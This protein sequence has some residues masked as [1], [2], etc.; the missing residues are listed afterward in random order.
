MTFPDMAHL[1]VIIW[2]GW[3]IS[4]TVSA[5]WTGRN[6]R[7]LRSCDALGARLLI[8]FGALMLTNWAARIAGAE[9]LWQT[10]RPTALLLAVLT[11]T[12]ILFAWWARIHLGLM[13]SG[14]IALKQ[15]HR[16]VESGPYALVRH[17]I[18]VGLL[19]A[20]FATAIAQGTPTAFAGWVLLA[21]GASIKARIEERFLAAELASDAYASYRSR[22]PMMLPFA[23]FDT[24]YRARRLLRSA[25][26]R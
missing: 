18:Y 4:W 25:V 20:T 21:C 24:V 8:V 17:P 1:F 10:D 9:R 23:S 7:R 15:G 3:A 13:W 26:C 14:G 2:L 5:V 22:V 12:G 11:L 6:Y 19:A 16:V